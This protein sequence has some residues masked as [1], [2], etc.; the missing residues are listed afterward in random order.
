MEKSVRKLRELALK[1]IK[2]YNMLT[3][4]MS[5]VIGFSGGP[6][7][8]CLFDFMLG[9]RDEFNLKLYPVHIN[10][11]LRGEDSDD[12]QSFCEEYARSHGID[13]RV[14]SFDCDS[15][16]RENGMS[17]EEAGRKFRYSA[18]SEVANEAL[19]EN[20]GKKVSIA[21]AQN[22]DDQAETV[23]MR[24]IRGTGVDGLSGIPYK[25]PIEEGSDI[26]II[27]PLLSVFREDIE[28]YLVDRNL[29]PRIDHTNM[30]AVYGRNKI[31][32]N[33]LPYLQEYNP[34]IKEALIRLA[35]SAEEDGRFL[36]AVSRIVYESAVL[37]KKESEVSFNR[38]LLK[39][40]NPAIRRR[41]LA[42]ALKD[43]GLIEDVGSVHYEAITEVLLSDNPS[44][45]TNLPGGYS[46]WRVYDTI[47]L[48]KRAEEDAENSC[49][50]KDYSFEVRE[51]G[52]SDLDKLDKIPNTYSAFDLSLMKK[53]YGEDVL[54]RLE[55]R[56]RRPGDEIKTAAGTK[57]I[58]DLLVD[59]KIPKEKRDLVKLLAIGNQVLWVIPEGEEYRPRYTS[60]WKITGETDK[61]AYIVLLV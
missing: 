26:N 29:I 31:R 53:E 40:E 34:N 12:D 13:L 56:G 2:E 57:K 49:N 39:D 20:P 36:D 50:L 35:S 38:S 1:N 46:A 42:L 21:V 33:L 6:D 61:I 58:Q 28:A 59:M 22:A 41:V 52:M 10:H 9:I 43:A 7:S 19:N 16:A 30:E 4:G 17:T 51:I 14:Y 47:N 27:R 60:K 44:T 55:L 25:R 32:L 11:N 24:I 23:L 48:G 15:F 8:L 18:F 5:V 37:K 54:S 3:E 45:H